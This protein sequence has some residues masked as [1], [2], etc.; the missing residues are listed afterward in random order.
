M[1]HGGES[2][3]TLYM[4]TVMALLIKYQLER[5]SQVRIHV[6]QCKTCRVTKAQFESLAVNSNPG[7]TVKEGFHFSHTCS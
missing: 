1:R 7:L 6:A 3:A 5:L 2:H 4:L